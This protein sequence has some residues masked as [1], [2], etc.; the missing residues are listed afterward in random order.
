MKLLLGLIALVF[1]GLG[2]YTYIDTNNHVKI[3]TKKVSLSQAEGLEVGKS[4]INAPTNS[5][6]KSINHVKKH[7][8]FKTA[9]KGSNSIQLGEEEYF[10]DNLTHNNELELANGESIGEGITLEDIERADVSSEVKERMLD[11]LAHY[12]VLSAE[13]EARKDTEQPI[14]KELSLEVI[15]EAT[16]S[17]DEKERMLDDL[18]H[19]QV[20]NAKLMES[21]Q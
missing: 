3:V 20:E 19:Y 4:H 13:A 21:S 17:L 12:Q 14:G 10:I 9:A 2:I 5:S 16:V 1:V 15:N 6:S 18:A 7:L 11:D 8:D